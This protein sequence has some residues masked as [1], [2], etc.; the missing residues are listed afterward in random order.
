[1]RYIFVDFE[2]NP[3][4]EKFPEIKKQCKRE[5]IEI[6]AVKVQNG[7]IVD[8]FSTFVNP[9]VPIPFRIEQL[10]SI[11]DS[12]VIDAP[13]IADI[14]PE[15]MKFCEGSIMVAHNAEFDMSFIKKNCD[16]QGISYDFTIGDTMTLAQLLL[17]NLNRFRL[18]TVAKAIGVHLGNHHR[19]VDDAACTADIFLKFI[20]MLKERGIHTLDEVNAEGNIDKESVRKMKSFH[21]IMLATNDIGRVN[22]YKLVSLSHLTYFNKRPKIPKSEFVK[23]RALWM[24]NQHTLMLTL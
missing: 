2:M 11:N 22:L 18:D 21:A 9:Q 16:R 7:K 6:G 15:F 23:Y 5:I 17:P 20:E 14:L 4:S 13:V 10:T 8:K 24:A 3:V 19:A 1:M 12:M